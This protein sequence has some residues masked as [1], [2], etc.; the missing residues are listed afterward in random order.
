MQKTASSVDFSSPETLPISLLNLGEKKA[1]VKFI[2]RT[3]YPNVLYSQPLPCAFI[4][5]TMSLPPQSL[6]VR[7]A[8]VTAAAALAVLG[9]LIALLLW[10]SLLQSSLQL[11]VDKA[12]HHI[13]QLHPFAF[14]A[15]LLVPLFLMALGMATGIGLFR[16]HAWS[17]KAALIWAA[18]ALVFC[19]ST[20]AFRPFETFA[21]PDHFVGETE[22]FEQLLA[23]SFVFMLLPISIWWLFFFRLKSVKAQFGEHEPI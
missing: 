13:Y 18:I 1:N 16:L 11:P 6:P 22:S 14:G 23:V 5:S 12:G 17:R 8:G 15:L 7:S 3:S 20:I 10:S 4:K 2:F 21:I 9:S 19:L